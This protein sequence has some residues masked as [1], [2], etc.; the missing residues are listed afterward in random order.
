MLTK[1]T[2]NLDAISGGWLTLGLCV[3]SRE[4]DF[5]GAP[6]SF[7]NRGKWFDEQL[8][9]IKRVWAGESVGNGVGP[10]GLPPA[11]AGEPEILIGGFSP[12]ALARAG[13]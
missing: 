8:V 7:S 9:L 11:R 3:G 1:Q 6:V 12:A 2:A 5:L 10:V 13:K 4:Y